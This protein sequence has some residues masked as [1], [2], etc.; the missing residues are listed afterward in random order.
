MPII[1]SFLD[2]DLYK[3]TQNQIVLHQFSDTMVEYHFK[4]RNKGVIF[5]TGPFNEIRKEIE[6]LGELRFK[7]GEL[8]Y[9]SNL[10]FISSDY[11]DF[12]RIFRFNTKMVSV[13][14][15]QHSE[16]EIKVKGPWLHTILF[17]IFILSIVNE[18]YFKW[19]I[20]DWKTS[21][22]NMD[23]AKEKLQAKV[24]WL[25]G[26]FCPNGF[27]FSEFGTRRRFSRHW[28]HN[29][30][31]PELRSTG[32][33]IG[34]SNVLM[35]KELDLIPIGTQAHEYY[36]VGQ[37]IGVRLVDSQKY[38]LEKWVQEYRGDLG[39]ALTDVIGIDA[40][41][42][43]FD[44]YFAKLYDGV[45]HDSG[46]AYIW[47]N[48]VID[49]YES[50]GIDPKTKTLVFS[51]GLDFD[52]ALNLYNY[53]YEYIK[54]GFGIG[55]WLTNDVGLEPLNIVLKIVECNGQPVAKIS[56]SPGKGMCNDPEYVKYLKK[57]FKVN[58]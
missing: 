52:K 13:N 50:L 6:N 17:E 28:Q 30:V 22:F 18:V 46:D 1:E 8:E 32:K 25:K 36:Q 5:E 7:E 23:I 44:L 41:L 48:K 56:D 10:S 20:G 42:R 49:H 35:A 45:R 16:L 3:I 31:L 4:C 24:D 39:I 40:F 34:T 57:V 43:D 33:L 29:Y 14:L 15:N 27:R 53:F 58:D 26:P 37:A 12:L 38:M 19:E 11:I 21:G 51:D 54:V 9:L 47:G 55:T 2:Q